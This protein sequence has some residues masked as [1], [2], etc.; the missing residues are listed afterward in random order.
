[1]K[2][3]FCL[4]VYSFIYLFVYLFIQPQQVAASGEFRADYEVQY[5]IAP[6]GV[7][8]VTQNVTLTN[9]L[10]NLYPQQYSILIDSTKINNIIAYDN[11]GVI[12]PQIKQEDGKTEI[13]LTFNEKVVGIGKQLKFSLRYESSDIAIQNGSIWDVN[14]PGVAEDPDLANYFVSLR[15]PPSFGVNAYMSPLPAS[16]GRW[17]REQMTQGGISAA[18]GQNQAFDL[19]LSYFLE[20]PTITPKLTELALP[21]DTAFQKIFIKSLTPA[22]K[23]VLQDED[24]NWLAQYDLL[25]AQRIE[26]K[27]QITAQIFLSMRDGFTTTLKDKKIYT[28]PTR[29][30]ESNDSR[31]A[32]LAKTYT[33]PRAIYTYVVNTLNYDYKRIQGIP[34]R[35]GALQALQSPLNSIC[36]EFTDLFIAIARA[37]GIPAREAVGYAHTTNARLRPL[38]FVSDVLHAWPEYYDEELRNWIPVDPTWADTTGGINYFDKLDFNHVVFA[39]HGKSSEYPYPAGYYKKAGEHTKDIQ[40]TFAKAIPSIATQKI[41]ISYAFPTQTTAGFAVSGQVYI[42]NNGETAVSNIPVHIQSTPVDVGIDQTIPSI[43]PYGKVAIP[44]NLNIP[45]YLYKGSGSVVTTVEDQVKKHD[46]LILP[47]GYRLAL[48]IGV[49]LC[50]VILLSIVWIRWGLW[51]RRKKH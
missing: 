10:S 43:P 47:L 29:Y 44:V 14:I 33:T 3:I 23:T 37:A 25:P 40:V 20:N 8:I 15:V 6:T 1:M 34:I 27:A 51:K 2:K 31:I 12:K 5:A 48:P 19:S 38:S 13:I 7:T 11:S 16:G 24:G 18:Y 17:T 50:I 21:P 36:M 46:F 39:Y 22:P 26:V 9:Q 4:L 45:T 28:Q 49:G 30:W 42:E 41:D 32:E 35:K